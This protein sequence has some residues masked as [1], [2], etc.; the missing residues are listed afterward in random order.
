MGQDT[1]TIEQEIAIAAPP[2]VVWRALTDAEELKRWFAVD[3]RVDPGA[4]GKVWISWGPGSEA[5]EGIDIWEPNRHLRISM[6]SEGM[7]V[8][9]ATDYYLEGRGGT[10]V[11]RLVV[12]GFGASADWDDMYF[13]MEAGWRYF[14][15]H[16][17][18]YLERHRGVPR[19]LAFERRQMSAD[20]VKMRDALARQLGGSADA[21]L[22][23]GDRIRV[24]L[25]ESVTGEVVLAP[26]GALVARLPDLNDAVLFFEL[27]PGGP[28]YHLGAWLS[29]YG[30]PPSRVEALRAGLSRFLDGLAPP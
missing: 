15:F 19:G 26:A 25:G 23:P 2:D 14:L 4:G 11:L 7:P 20:R 30:L 29:T 1:R 18:H 22:L 6:Q 12:S 8:P 17:R 16:L 5:A 24:N 9:F 10:T 3:A 21:D 13:G 27:E 28:Q